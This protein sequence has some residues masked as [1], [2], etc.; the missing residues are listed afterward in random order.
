MRIRIPLIPP[1]RG[2]LPYKDP[3]QQR[4]YQRE[5]LKRTRAE[6]FAG[7]SCVKC[8]SLDELELDHIDPSTK[9]NHKIWSWSPERRNA[10]LAK[11][12]VLCSVCHLNKTRFVDLASDAAHGTLAR[13]KSGVR[14]GQACRCVLCKTANAEYE[15]ARR[16]S[17]RALGVV[18]SISVLQTEGVGS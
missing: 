15:A 14:I 1:Y 16:K 6:W 2:N 5:R 12:Q 11:C 3:E 8:G 9:I 13:Y 17:K 7:K 18:G 10:E 4:A